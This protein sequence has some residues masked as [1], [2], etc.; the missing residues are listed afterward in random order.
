MVDLKISV[1]PFACNGVG[2]VDKKV[3]IT[4]ILQSFHFLKSIL[5]YKLNFVFDMSNSKDPIV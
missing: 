1:E 2:R 4:A 3:T 5:G